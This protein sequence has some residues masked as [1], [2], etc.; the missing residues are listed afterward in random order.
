MLTQLEPLLSWCSLLANSLQPLQEKGSLIMLLAACPAWAGGPCPRLRDMS[1]ATSLSHFSHRSSTRSTVF[2]R[3]RFKLSHLEDLTQGCD[4]SRPS[5]TH[6]ENQQPSTG[7]TQ[8]EQAHRA[9]LQGWSQKEHNLE[10][11]SPL[12]SGGTQAVSKHL[13]NPC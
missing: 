4:N 7:C 6:R 3:A 9:R 10:L 2:P 11:E 13:H 12:P 5:T 8:T 1:N